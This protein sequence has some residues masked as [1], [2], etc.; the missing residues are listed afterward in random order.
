MSVFRFKLFFQRR[1]LYLFC[2]GCDKNFTQEINDNIIIDKN[3]IK[4]HD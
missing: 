3:N 2:K 1:K 4:M